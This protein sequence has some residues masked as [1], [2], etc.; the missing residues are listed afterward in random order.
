MSLM[1]WDPVREMEDLSSR[2]NQWFG[3]PIARRM[4]DENGMTL[5]NWAPAVD[6]EETDKEYVV[7]ADLPDIRKDDLKIRIDDG[8]LS[9]EGERRQEKEQQGVRFHRVERSYGKFMRRLELPMEIDQ[10]KVS[11]EFKDGVVI[12]HLP[13][14]HEARPKT[15]DVKVM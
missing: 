6:V 1:R 2:L 12:V 9:L 4:G 13:K 10:Q 14:T 15:I 8:V 7:K 11:A 5:A 3:Q